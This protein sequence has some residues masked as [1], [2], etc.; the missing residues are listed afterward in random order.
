M[1]GYLKSLKI[2]Q[3]FFLDMGAVRKAAGAADWLNCTDP[4]GSTSDCLQAGICTSLLQPY[5]RST[6]S[7]G[8][9]LPFD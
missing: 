9:S 3:F 6:F 4:T 2:S 8:Y 1:F 7:P 5:L